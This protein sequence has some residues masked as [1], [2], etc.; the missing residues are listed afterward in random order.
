[1]AKG[2]Y[3]PGSGPK[4]GSKFKKTLDKEAGRALVRELVLREIEPMVMAQVAHARGI[5]YAVVRRTDGTFTRVTTK[6]QLDEA[7]AQGGQS[8][9]V[10]TQVPSTAAFT[11]LLNRALDKPKEQPMEMEVNGS[12]EVTLLEKIQKARARLQKPEGPGR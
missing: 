10:Y 6:K 2:G 4:K 5:S 11:D 7:I 3:R 9:Q 8:L 1:M 12:L